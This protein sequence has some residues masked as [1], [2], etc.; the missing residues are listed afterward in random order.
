LSRKRQGCLRKGGQGIFFPSLGEKTALQSVGEGYSR[1]KEECVQ[2]AADK[3]SAHRRKNTKL[4]QGVN[5]SKV[6]RG[7]DKGLSFYFKH[8]GNVLKGLYGGGLN[9]GQ[10]LRLLCSCAVGQV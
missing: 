1:Q 6:R 10:K 8:S 7:H 4:R 9:V 2:Q 5:R 3:R